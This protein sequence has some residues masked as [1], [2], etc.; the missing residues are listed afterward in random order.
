VGLDPLARSACALVHAKLKHLSCT[1]SRKLGEL[2]LSPGEKKASSPPKQLPC[3]ESCQTFQFIAGPKRSSLVRQMRAGYAKTDRASEN[4]I[5]A[6]LFH[7]H[8]SGRPVSPD[9]ERS[10]ANSR[11]R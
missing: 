7:E 3:L 4:D 5:N 10:L 1:K 8:A 11:C 2:T 9:F 6:S